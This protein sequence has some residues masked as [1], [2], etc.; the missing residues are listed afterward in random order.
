[1]KTENEIGLDS[2]GR[3]IEANLLVFL[4]FKVFSSV[5]NV[6]RVSWPEI[7]NIYL[8]LAQKATLLHTKE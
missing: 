8:C 2:R 3:V 1:M 7:Q 6:I 5:M 4:I